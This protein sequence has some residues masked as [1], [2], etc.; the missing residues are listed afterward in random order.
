M[1]DAKPIPAPDYS[2]GADL[3]CIADFADQ[4]IT[5]LAISPD[6]RVF[7]NLP[8]WASDTAISVG[9]VIDGEIRAYPDAE[10]NSWRNADE[11]SPRHHFV[12][13]QSVV[14]DQEG[15]LWVLDPASPAMS[16]PVKGRPQA[17]EDRRFHEQG[18][19]HDRV[20]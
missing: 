19:G 11:K 3:V 2:R 8:R 6:G 1:P 7:V 20:R 10:W 13:V 15:F 18:G 12:C 4:Q 9:E 5:G 14:F 16:G 17:G